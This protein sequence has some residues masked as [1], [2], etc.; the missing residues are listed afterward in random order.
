MGLYLLGGEVGQ[1]ILDCCLSRGKGDA[2]AFG[3]ILVD[4]GLDKPLSICLY[5]LNQPPL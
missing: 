5:P 3:Q 1:L 4:G 2:M